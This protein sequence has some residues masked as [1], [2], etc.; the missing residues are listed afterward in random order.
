MTK[1]KVTYSN[2]GEKC[3]LDNSVYFVF[4][5]SKREAAQTTEDLKAKTESFKIYSIEG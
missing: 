5:D 4:A 3:I 1:F 2:N